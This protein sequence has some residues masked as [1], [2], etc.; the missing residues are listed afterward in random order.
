M[1]AIVDVMKTYSKCLARFVYPFFRKYKIFFCLQLLVTF[2]SCYVASF[3]Q[4]LVCKVSAIRLSFATP[5]TTQN[6]HNNYSKDTQDY[7]LSQDYLLE[8]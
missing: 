5:Y 7:F 2:D 8:N 3:V 4:H 1:Q 6:L